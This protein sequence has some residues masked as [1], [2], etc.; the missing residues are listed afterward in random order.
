MWWYERG[1]RERQTQAGLW[2]RRCPGYSS[3]TKVTA[4]WSVQEMEKT[5][6]QVCFLPSLMVSFSQPPAPTWLYYHPVS[7]QGPSARPYDTPRFLHTRSPSL[8]IPV[9]TRPWE[10]SGAQ[11]LRVLGH[12]HW[13]E[14]CGPPVGRGGMAVPSRWF[15]RAPQPWLAPRCWHPGQRQKAWEKDQKGYKEVQSARSSHDT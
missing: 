2:G 12:W 13:A 6:T 1:K 9:L 8:L 11:N 14:G 10:P 5:S 3:W 7:S 4:S 15:Y